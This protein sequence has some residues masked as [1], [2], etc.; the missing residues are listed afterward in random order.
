MSEV[1][2][3]QVIL[4]TETTG[5][6][7]KQGHRVIE[8]GCVEVVAR[9]LTGVHFHEYIH[10]D[11]VVEEEAIRIHGIT[12]E[13]LQDKP[14]FHIVA[15]AFVEYVRGAELIIHN[16]AFDIGFLN[17]E[18]NLMGHPVKDLRDIC[19]VTDTLAMARERY[20]GQR[21]TLD[22]LC[23]RLFVDNSKRTLHGALLDSEILADVYLR[24]T[25]GQKALLLSDDSEDSGQDELQS[26]ALNLEGV[27]LKVVTAKDDELEAHEAWLEML[28]KGG[29][30]RW[31]ELV[32]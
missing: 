1:V 14:F 6:D 18:L 4:D 19:Q 9:R 17:H 28:D 5:L 11:R 20:P 27:Q 7:P 23:K 25:G 16:A 30:C 8:I 26:S 29:S 21:N 10:P 24:M 31:R 2:T 32:G 15:D 12:N 22:A 3:R 13:F